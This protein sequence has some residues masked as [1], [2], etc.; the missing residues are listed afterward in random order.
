[1]KI[2][3][4]HNIFCSVFYAFKIKHESLDSDKFSFYKP[5]NFQAF[6]DQQSTNVAARTLKKI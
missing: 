5:E 2:Q 6:S 4:K 3:N 1:M